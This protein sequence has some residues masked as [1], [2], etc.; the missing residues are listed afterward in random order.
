M[1]TT[2]IAPIQGPNTR[3]KPARDNHL[4]ARW[5]CSMPREGPKTLYTAAVMSLTTGIRLVVGALL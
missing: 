4:I 3:Q 2:H 1:L 5:P